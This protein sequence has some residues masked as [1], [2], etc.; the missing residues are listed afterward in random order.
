M[1]VWNMHER[2][3]DASTDGIYGRDHGV[4]ERRGWPP[5]ANL[6]ERDAHHRSLFFFFFFFLLLR[7]MCCP[8]ILVRNI[9]LMLLPSCS[10]RPL[11]CLGSLF[12]PSPHLSFMNAQ[13]INNRGRSVVL[14]CGAVPSFF[15]FLVAA[16]ADSALCDASEI[17]TEDEGEG[18]NGPR[19]TGNL[20][21]CFCTDGQ[22]PFRFF[23]THTHTHIHACIHDGYW[24]PPFSQTLVLFGQVMLIRLV[25]FL[26]Q[27]SLP[28]LITF[29]RPVFNAK[30][31][32]NSNIL[33]SAR[34]P[35]P[36]FAGSM[37]NYGIQPSD[38]LLHAL[39]G[40]KHFEQVAEFIVM[41]PSTQ[42]FERESSKVDFNAFK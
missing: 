12:F 30:N 9:S 25:Q 26:S 7:L 21:P 20:W 5:G 16:Q 24:V 29:V 31:Y 28:R 1:P 33:L 4:P 34:H 22:I 19:A 13:T 27:P 42:L 38:W 17:K 35:F 36:T 15:F 23:S 11:L 14:G 18:N 10:S 39:F 37:S 32:M 8:L 3:G 40:R 2:Y 6:S 41:R